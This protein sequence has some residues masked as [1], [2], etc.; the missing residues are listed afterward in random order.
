MNAG[1]RP[2]FRN[3]RAN[4]FMQPRDPGG[5]RQ[6]VG[7]DGLLAP[8]NPS[9]GELVS[10]KSTERGI[11]NLKNAASRDSHRSKS[12]TNQS[13]NAQ[14]NEF[15]DITQDV[16]QSQDPLFEKKTDNSLL[17]DSPPAKKA[18]KGYVS[19]KGQTEGKTDFRGGMSKADKLT[20]KEESNKMKTNKEIRMLK[21]LEMRKYTFKDIVIRAN[22]FSS[23]WSVTSITAHRHVRL[24]LLFLHIYM[25]FFVTAVMLSFIRTKK[26][27][28]TEIYRFIG[29]ISV[30]EFFSSFYYSLIASALM[31]VYAG[32]YKISDNRLR[33]A[34]DV[35]NYKE[36]L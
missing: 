4:N 3:P 17:E 19:G 2:G 12:R 21:E 20:S 26:V 28:D 5:S 10:K 16:N 31:Y 8:Y 34:K 24:T 29:T 15:S 1:N 36:M 25:Q 14:R 32:M 35:K 6:N 9:K 23:L 33:L 27:A 30:D 22:W 13:L 18:A 7:P 11:L